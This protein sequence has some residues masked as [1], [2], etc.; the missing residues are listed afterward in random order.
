MDDAE[1]DAEEDVVEEDEVEEALVASSEETEASD[2]CHCTSSSGVGVQGVHAR[3]AIAHTSSP[4][5]A[6]EAVTCDMPFHLLSR[7]M[8]VGKRATLST[9]VT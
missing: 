6:R 4:H 3:W 8:P 2:G 5:S 9:G 7:E 1:D